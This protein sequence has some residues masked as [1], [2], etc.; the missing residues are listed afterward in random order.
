VKLGYH[1][2]EADPSPEKPVAQE[3]AAKIPQ[4]ACFTV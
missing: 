2:R 4:A 3:K 1:I